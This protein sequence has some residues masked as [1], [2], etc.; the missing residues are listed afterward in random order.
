[1]NSFTEHI[2][3]A[4]NSLPD[5]F[6]DIIIKYESSASYVSGEY[7]STLAQVSVTGTISSYSD[8]E[9]SQSSGTI[10][11]KDVKFKLYPNSYNLF[12][13]DMKKAVVNSIEY[14]VI[15]TKLKASS[16]VLYIQLRRV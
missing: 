4:I 5:A 12:F 11:N 14:N 15:S 16:N 1:M 3:A 13:V 6:V 7:K 10:L 9:I 8:L 2:S